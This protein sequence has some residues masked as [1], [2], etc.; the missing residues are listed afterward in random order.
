MPPRSEAAT[1]GVYGDGDQTVAQLV[2][3]ARAHERLSPPGKFIHPA[4]GRFGAGI[5]GA[6]RDE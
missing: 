4:N 2:D 3:K 1:D 6:T 5:A